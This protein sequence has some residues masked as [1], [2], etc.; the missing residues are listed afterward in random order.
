MSKLLK[1]L[2]RN[3]IFFITSWMPPQWTAAWSQKWAQWKKRRELRREEKAIKK[4]KKLAQRRHAVDGRR[5]YVLPDWNGDLM[6]LNNREIDQLKRH[7]V[8][9]K[10]VNVKHL[11]DEAVYFTP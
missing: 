5:Y 6:V 2:R 4:A 10:R 1:Q 9:S 3:F 8:M 11:L 7:G